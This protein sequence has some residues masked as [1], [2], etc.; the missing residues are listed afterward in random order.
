MRMR[1]NCLVRSLKH[2]VIRALCRRHEGI[3]ETASGDESDCI[4]SSFWGS[5]QCRSRTPE[6]H[7]RRG[8]SISHIAQNFRHLNGHCLAIV[9]NASINLPRE[10]AI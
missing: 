6:S 10:P 8:V 9:L 4:D 2:I 1:R 3:S 7:R 5:E